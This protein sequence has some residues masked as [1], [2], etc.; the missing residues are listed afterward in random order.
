MEGIFRLLMPIWVVGMWGIFYYLATLGALGSVHYILLFMTHFLCLL[1][2]KNFVWIFNYS[3]ALSVLLASLVI[4][5]LVQPPLVPAL[6][7]LTISVYGARLFYF[8]YRRYQASSYAGTM[9]RSKAADEA[10]PLFVKI[11]IWVFVSWLMFYH[12]FVSYFVAAKAEVNDWTLL[13]T[14]FMLAGL[15]IETVADVQKQSAKER[16]P[17]TFCQTGLYR[18]CRHPNYLGEIIFIV[19]MY[20]VGL[21]IFDEAYQYIAALPTPLWI[22]ILMVWS[23]KNSDRQQTERYGDR[24]EYQAWRSRVPCLLPKF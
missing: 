1:V 11:I 20:W 8:V 14:L 22:V 23:A 3:Y 12:S 10:M 9:Q 15:L 16:D 24:P 5:A 6:V 7:C 17:S 13:A 4:V 19:G 18:F 2:F 21:T